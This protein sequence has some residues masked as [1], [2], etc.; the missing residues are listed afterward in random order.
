MNKSR[1]VILAA[2]VLA[3]LGAQR[4]TSAQEPRLRP[5][6]TSN[7][8][9]RTHEILI[10]RA[11][12]RE[13]M[14]D[15]NRPARLHPE[16]RGALLRLQS[17]PD[18]GES[19]RAIFPSSWW[20]MSDNGI[21]DRW[22]T[23]NKD[24]SDF[25]SDPDNLSPVEKYDLLMN[26]GEAQR[27]PQVRAFTNEEMRR[28]ERERGAGRVRPS[29]VVAGPATAWELLNHGTYQSTVPEDWW[30]HC[31]G[32]SSYATAERDGAPMRDVRVR[33]ENGRIVACNGERDRGCVLFRMA[34]IEALFS[35]VYFH[36]SSTMAGNR[37]N[38]PEDDIT[39]DNAGRPTNP[40]CRD[41]NPGTLH[42]A[43]T[44]LMGRGAPALA[45]LGGPR[46]K[47]PFV[48]DYAYGDEVWTFPIV[49]YRVQEN[50]EIDE[51]RASQLVCNGNGPA[52]NCRTYRW[53]E[54]AV[55][56]ARIRTSAYLVNYAA[57]IEQ[58]L[59]PPLQRRRPLAE[60]TF[61]YVLEL[62]GRGTILG[63]EWIDSPTGV[64]PNSKE[65]HPDFI[66]MSAFPDASDE[67]GDDTGGR[68]DNP[69]I[70]YVAIQQILRISR[71]GR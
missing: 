65:L 16:L 8:F 29:I 21:A 4:V 44:G 12:G 14:N 69:H 67:A 64:G 56:F 17:G 18:A 30:G 5:D 59:V 13:P 33:R 35:E 71:N 22:N 32:W 42:I 23:A 50:E 40:A 25:R 58:L 28:P 38:V 36:D 3:L 68:G 52:G 43:L 10:P 20:P 1:T 62:D 9:Y 37:C 60:V 54:N 46:E 55:R 19:S 6:F 34:D 61:H 27:L 49:R 2:S 15:T 11:P 24:Y 31:N 48:M 70:S 26:P 41:L 45:N 66:Y 7:G 47:L 63:G 39:T 51:R 57:S 53:N